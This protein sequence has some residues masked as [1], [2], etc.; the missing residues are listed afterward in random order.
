MAA[1]FCEDPPFNQKRISTSNDNTP[2]N[3]YPDTQKNNHKKSHMPSMSKDLPPTLPDA[4]APPGTHPLSI[5]LD[6]N[7]GPPPGQTQRLPQLASKIK[8][9][10]LHLPHPAWMYSP[11]PPINGAQ[12]L[13]QSKVKSLALSN[14]TLSYQHFY[15]HQDRV[16]HPKAFAVSTTATTVGDG[17]KPKGSTELDDVTGNNC[18]M[19]KEE[20]TIVP[21]P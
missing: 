20:Y 7:V 3:T 2:H 9:M 5:L 6:E 13:T 21:L 14:Y 17:S 18:A 15:F 4:D 16:L 1:L 8:T 11:L 10:P 12:P 19:T